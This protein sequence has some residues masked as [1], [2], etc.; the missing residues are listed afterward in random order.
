[1]TNICPITKS[2]R[3]RSAADKV[4]AAL[5]PQFPRGVAK[6]ALRALAGAGLHRLSDLSRVGESDVAAL[7]GMGPKALGL[8]RT[9]LAAQG[10]GF[11]VEKSKPKKTTGAGRF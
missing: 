10:S 3:K 4:T 9:A 8:L 7:H 2:P 6:P 1:M 11:R 5:Q